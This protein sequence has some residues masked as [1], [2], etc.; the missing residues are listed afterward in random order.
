ME[1]EGCQPFVQ[2]IL[3][4][5]LDDHVQRI[6]NLSV[7]PNQFFLHEVH[8]TSTESWLLLGL[9]ITAEFLAP[10]AFK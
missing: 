6:P 2:L 5:P 4:S 8:P 3:V 10:A 1:V 7:V 9:L